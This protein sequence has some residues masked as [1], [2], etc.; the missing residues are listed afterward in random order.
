[1]ISVTGHLLFE[2]NAMDERSI[3]FQTLDKDDPTERDTFLDHACAGDNALRQRVDALLRSHATAGQF[4]NT[5]VAQ[6]FVTEERPP[7]DRSP[8][9]SESEPSEAS[10]SR[11]SLSFL[12]PSQRADSLGILGQYEV[13]QI[14]GRGGMGLV[15]RAIDARLNRTVAIKVLA[16]A[17]A[18]ME[19]ARQRFV[20]EAQTAAAVNHENIIAIHSVDDQSLVPYIVMQMIEG[21]SLQEK[22]ERDGA[23]SIPEVLDIAPQI[24]SGLA[25]AHARG[26]VHRDIKPANILIE[27]TTKRIRITDFGLARAVDDASLTQSGMIAGTPGYMSPE[28]ANG[29]AVDHRSDL[30][31]LGSVLYFLCTGRPP[32]VSGSTIAT[33]KRV[34]SQ[35][36]Q[37]IGEVIS[38]VPPWLTAIIARLHA[39]SSA[40]RCQS[41]NE[42]LELLRLQAAGHLQTVQN[43]AIGDTND[44]P[45]QDAHRFGGARLK[46]MA[47]SVALIGVAMIG[48][49]GIGR[50]FWS[51]SHVPS[52]PAAKVQ[53]EKTAR[54]LSPADL[55]STEPP[56]NV[57]SLDAR[58]RT[59]VSTASLVRLGNGKA[60]DAPQELIGV[61]EETSFLLPRSGQAHWMSQS[62]DGRL[63]AVPS[64][65]TVVLFDASTGELKRILTGAVQRVFRTAF[66]PDN[67]LVAAGGGNSGARIWDVETGELLTM[68]GSESLTTLCVA[69]SPDGTKLASCCWDGTIHVWDVARRSLLYTMT[70]HMGLAHQVAF[71]PN[72]HQLASANWD[73]TVSIW[74][75]ATGELQKTLGGHRDT[76]L[77][78]AWQ[79]DGRLLATGS[80][81]EVLIWDAM[82]FEQL[83]KLDTSGA[84]LLA[85]GP[86]GHSV[87]TAN[88]K[89]P[90]GV[91]WSLSKWNTESGENSANLPLAGTGVLVAS[92]SNDGNTLWAMDAE[93]PD[94]HVN[95][96]DAETGQQKESDHGHR[97]AVLSLA[98]SPD[99]NELAS[100]GADG[101][102][103]IWD[104]G[105]WT[106]EKAQPTVRTLG[107]QS[108]EVHS[109]AFS[110]DRH[111]LIAKHAVGKVT[112]WDLESGTDQELPPEH[113][114]E[115]SEAAVSPDGRWRAFAKE[116]GT[117]QLQSAAT[118]VA[119]QVFSGKQPFTKLRFSSRGKLLA[120]VNNGPAPALCIWQLE[121]SVDRVLTG[122][123]KDI[124]DLAFNAAESQ[125]ATVSRDGTTRIWD[126]S[127]GTTGVQVIDA[128][129]LGEALSVAFSPEGRHVAVGY[130]DG[131]I[132]IFRVEP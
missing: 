130:N 36:P 69:F 120:A 17:L 47:A 23:L 62:P 83:R 101:S 71:S 73:R 51:S 131:T 10:E 49:A 5:P 42:V 35:E 81:R 82:T 70:A 66:S 127:P 40:D 55:T 21:M 126:L 43:E 44:A 132:A 102:T 6:Q 106:V 65:N 72:G 53:T 61:L 54:S 25:A 80:E 76:V 38:D 78:V 15:F 20:R 87:F 121:R 89:A 97:G 103:R 50:S 94:P 95:V 67:K 123:T 85:F 56:V 31:S 39:K 27:T 28:Q 79:P 59:N 19:S 41:A 108:D 90:E 8:A 129:G 33:L 2:L 111:Q 60:E 11:H 96:F 100:G 116:D 68:L 30:F 99:G 22:V 29:E 32:F 64:S 77:S 24:A 12:A 45:R 74:N 115:I 57:S 117:V 104:L 58:S 91:N 110:P 122:H 3:F 105:G 128:P 93:T 1:M 98:F 107:W 125:V 34:C 4:L 7:A 26:L 88:H 114:A 16:P 113:N 124:V 13:L 9:G 84:G 86:D 119:Q 37:P 112:R 118:G 48:L 46:W 18:A 75:A 92:L 52:D 63:L 109:L 14:I